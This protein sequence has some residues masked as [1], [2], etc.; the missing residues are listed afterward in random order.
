M[1]LCVSGSPWFH[2]AASSVSTVLSRKF[3]LASLAYL[4]L[5]AVMFWPLVRELRAGIPH[6]VGDP[7][8]NTWILWWDAHAVPFTERWWNGPAYWPLPDFLAFSEHLVG[9]SVLT[10]PLQWI[11]A[12]PQLAYN[13]LL[14]LSWPLCA[15][16]TYAFAWHV[17][18]RH[19][20]A[21]LAGLV[22][23]FNPYRLGQTPHVQVLACWWMPLALL[24]L[25][26]AYDARTVARAAPWLVLFGCSWLL[27]ALSN[28]YFLFYFSVLVGLWIAWFVLRPSTWR[29]ALGIVGT[30]CLAG[31]LTVPV[32]LKY[33][34]VT[35]QW[36][37]TR[38]INQIV[39]YS[40]DLTSFLTAS[41]LVRFWP[42]HPELRAEQGLY[43]GAIAVL[44]AT[45]GVIFA[46]V[47]HAGPS[48]ARRRITYGLLAIAAMFL[49]GAFSIF[50]FG[51]CEWH[52]GPVAISG[53]RARKPLSIA[54]LF[55]ALAVVFDPTFRRALRDRSVLAFYAT[56][57]LLCTAM[58]FGPT[59]R[60]MG[61]IILEKPPYWWLLQLPGIENLRVPTRFAMVAALPLAIT[62][63][64]GFA[65]FASRLNLR[66]QTVLATLCASLIVVD[67]WPLAIPMHAPREQYT[68][69]AAARDS[70]VIE[71]PFGDVVDNDI[72]AMIRGISH[73]RPVANGYT[74]YFP[75]PYGMLRQA[76]QERDPS[77]LRGLATF[78][79]L[80][81]V[82][83]RR[84]LLARNSRLMTEAAGAKLLG[85]D[86][87]FAFYRLERAPVPETPGETKAP[88]INA[89]GAMWPTPVQT[90]IDGRIETYW[91]SLTRQRGREGM[92]LT[93]RDTSDVRGV[94]LSLGARIGGYPRH[95][96]VE[97]SSDGQSWVS[98]WEGP[99]AGL[100]YRAAVTDVDRIRFPITF[101]PR[102]ARF[103]RLRQTGISSDAYWAIAEVEVLRD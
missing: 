65:H 6:D 42:F 62:A 47:A 54:V 49:L 90:P 72:A 87:E 89:V 23:G 56:A 4:G 58:C 36:H 73:G 31:A 96:V 93:L 41:S 57:A 103:V 67:S 10:T 26:R 53:R 79:P 28:G 91:E 98:A 94:A 14:L 52:L 71:L 20:A 16:A 7:L 102:P 32:L 97:T 45:G 33:K 30:W 64:L 15:I 83:D 55:I 43:P 38:G 92:T 39:A 2:S 68:L 60:V 11:G 66:L 12:G 78:A 99:T 82:I 69:P 75:G 8:L 3:W 25:H 1:R 76:L 77:V 101:A 100:A 48:R 44:I 35:E 40:A 70:A 74:G 17:T 5:T 61:E 21:F 19:D 86:R 51:P 63:A 46:A 18:R 95:L 59:G 29:L 50:A 34:A 37:L 84:L 13:V 22:F 80:C 88:I 9:L 81:I 24:A 85:T 27:Q